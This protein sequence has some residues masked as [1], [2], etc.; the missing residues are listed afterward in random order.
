MSLLLVVHSYGFKFFQYPYDF[1]PMF[2]LRLFLFFFHYKCL[3][4][5][6]LLLL[7]LF[8][9]FLSNFQD[10][11]LKR[12]GKD[13]Q[14]YD[15]FKILATKCSYSIFNRELV[16][17]ILENCLSRE[18]GDKYAEASADLLLVSTCLLLSIFM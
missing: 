10:S 16:H 3:L 14:C 13:H 12:I 18:D 6:Y 11:F 8:M 1:S 17:H 4:F 5:I 2:V 15:F 9:Y 7:L